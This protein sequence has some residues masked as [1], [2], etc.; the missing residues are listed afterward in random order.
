MVTGASSGIGRATAVH[1]S[2]LGARVVIVGRDRPRLDETLRMLVGSGHFAESFDLSS[3]DEIL[4]WVKR[5]VEL[6]GPFDGLAHAAGIQSY[7]PIRV[8]TAATMQ[9]MYQANTVSGAMLVRGL[10]QPGCMNPESSIVLVASTAA[11]LGVPANAAYGASKAA[12]IA[13]ARSMALELIGKRI[14]VNCVAPGLVETEMVQRARDVM[15]E[16]FFQ[17][18]VDKH[19]LGI[20][21]PLDVAHAITFF[22]APTSRWITGTTLMVDGGLSVP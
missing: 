11:I 9:E 20:G 13:L 15:P 3:G 5:L 22:L 19:P 10:L 17:A 1:L 18:M 8:L 21:Q 14:R 2:Q 16:E 12:L 6:Q 4:G 7:H